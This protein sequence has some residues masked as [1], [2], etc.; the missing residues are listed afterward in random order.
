MKEALEISVELQNILNE[1]EPKLQ[2]LSDE[3]ITQR[4]NNQ[5]RSI[6]M[7]IGHLID[8]ISN[9]IHRTIHLQNLPGP[10]VFPNYATM[11]NN[12]R[13]IAIQDYQSEDWSNLI[14][15][16]KYSLLHY[17]H[18]IRRIN[19]AKLDNKWI[20]GPDTLVSLQDMTLDFTRHFKL[21]IS[22]IEELINAHK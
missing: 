5:N 13:W 11:G 14:G 8:S 10:I 4:F 1:W 12:D 16:W 15:L 7:I 3:V 2:S 9:N 18:I 22:E 21:H 20:A 19:D 17:C 6:K